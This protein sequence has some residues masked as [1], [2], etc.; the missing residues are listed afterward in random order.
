RRRPRTGRRTC[1]LRTSGSACTGRRRRTRSGRGPRPAPVHAPLPRGP[2]SP[3]PAGRRAAV[4]PARP[5]ASRRRRLALDLLRRLTLA[6]LRLQL[7]ELVV[8]LAALGNL[9]QLAVD[10][11]TGAADVRK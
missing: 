11:V 6:D 1:G 3:T 9:L 10:V 5:P 7:R 8:D 4:P 2:R